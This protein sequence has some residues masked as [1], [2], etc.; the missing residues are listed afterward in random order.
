MGTFKI[1]LG[2]KLAHGYRVKNRAEV[3]GTKTQSWGIFVGGSH[4]RDNVV[5]NNICTSNIVG[6][7]LWQGTG[8]E[9][10]NN[11]GKTVLMDG[12]KSL[13][14]K[15]FPALAA[16]RIPNPGFEEG[17]GWKLGQTASFDS[18]ARSGERALKM[19]KKTAQGVLDAT[20]DFFALKPN[21]RYRLSAWVK[22]NAQRD[23]T[24]VLPCLF[25]CS[26]DWRVVGGLTERIR[27]FE[28][29]PP[30]PKPLTWLKVSAEA[31]TGPKP[32]EAR[33][34]CRFESGT[35]DVWFDDIALEEIHWLPST[36]VGP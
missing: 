12:S 11:V 28:V 6:G 14:E 17:T 18:A 26:R 24:L 23:D 7:I 1:K 22:S 16:V 13:E 2:G 35:G 15:V 3:V 31:E 5:A 10:A 19:T 9:V 21:T 34:Y 29:S 8:A 20:S 4:A 25:L 27:A 33:I 30:D 36:T 32:L